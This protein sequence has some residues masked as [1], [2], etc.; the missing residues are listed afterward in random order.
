MVK[1]AAW[2]VSLAVVLNIGMFSMGSVHAADQ[3]PKE[4]LI[5]INAPLTGM[6]AGFGEGNVYGEKAAVEDINK[7]GGILIK[8]YGRKIPLRV[9][10]W[11]TKV[12]L[13]R[14]GLLKKT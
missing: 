2:V 4:I 14:Q 11:T 12:T 8:E 13:E 1:I 6:H 5:G 10:S 7:Q 3:G 9:M